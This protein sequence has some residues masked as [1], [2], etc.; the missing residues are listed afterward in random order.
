MTFDEWVP[1]YRLLSAGLGRREK[2]EQ[3]RAYF[4]T[5]QR[6]PMS[7]VREAVSVV[8]S[9][10]W[11]KATRPNAGDL[12]EATVGV[13]RG[14]RVSAEVCDVCHGDRFTVT[15]CEGWKGGATP[16]PVNR[17]AVCRRPWPH[18]AHEEAHPCRQCHP[19]ALM[20]SREHEVTV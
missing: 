20:A 12:A 9:R 5:L 11:D 15:H 8:T 14:R 4:E 7:A 2:P 3:A 19:L 18:A 16:E 17:Q 10:V 1:L 6:F 13:M